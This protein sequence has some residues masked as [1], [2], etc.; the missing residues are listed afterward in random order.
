MNKRIL[1]TAFIITCLFFSHQAF[2]KSLHFG[3][4]SAIEDKIDELREESAEIPKPEKLPYIKLYSDPSPFNQKIPADAEVDPNSDVMLQSLKDAFEEGEFYVAQ[5]EWTV[6]VYFVDE[7]TP[8][9][10]VKLTADWALA[11]FLKDVPIPDFA[12]PD[13]EEDG[14]M[15]IIDTSTGCEYDF[16]QASK[17]APQDSPVRCRK[18]LER[19][20]IYKEGLQPPGRRRFFTYSWYCKTLVLERENICKEEKSWHSMEGRLRS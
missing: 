10:D 20:L 9:Y 6:P 15:A 14:E 17:N 11:R 3:I 5:K 8:R 1:L 12:E 4:I 2:A 16:W 19:T 13:P 18:Q 7:N